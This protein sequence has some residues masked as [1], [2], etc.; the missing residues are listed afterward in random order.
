MLSSLSD[1]NYATDP[2]NRHSISGWSTFLEGACISKKSKQQDI[3]TLSVTEAELFAAVACAQ[4]L[5]F[6]K[7]ALES[8]GLK[9]QLPMILK[10]DNKGAVDL[11]NS[12]SVRG[13]TRHMDCRVNYLR[14]LKEQGIILCQW[15]SSET[16]ASD[17]FTKNLGGTLFHRFMKVYCGIDKYYKEWMAALHDETASIDSE[18]GKSDGGG[19]LARQTGVPSIRLTS[20]GTANSGN[21]EKRRQE[22]RGLKTD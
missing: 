20:N 12:W 1:A 13:C 22:L 8:M 6:K 9:V 17:M 4:D 10:I 14:E 11:A 19:N 7:H 5:V 2:D 18:A 21:A 16:M 15:T 3:V